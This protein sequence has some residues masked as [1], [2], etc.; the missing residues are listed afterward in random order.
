MKIILSEDDATRLG[1]PR[2][3][4]YNENKLMGREAI[5]I[6]KATGWT[7]SALARALDGRVVLDEDGQPLYDTDDAGQ[8]VLDEDGRRVPLR[9]VD[10]EALVILVYVAVL[11][12][13]VKI[14]YADFDID[15]FGT[16]FGGE[17]PGKGP[18]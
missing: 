12:S 7:P 2:E 1:V 9:D 4:E 3:L 18:A 14:K 11:R 17:D 16:K 10:A 6:Q 15:F 8:P 13:G 5:A